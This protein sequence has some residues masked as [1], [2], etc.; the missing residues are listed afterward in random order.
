[1]K[2]AW[3][4]LL[5]LLIPTVSAYSIGDWPSFFVKDNKFSARYVVSDEAPSLDVVSATVISTSLAKFENLTIDVGTS[6]LDSEVGNITTI[7]A[8]VVASPC[9]SSSAFELM[10]RPDPCYRDLGGSVGYI[11][12]F[13]H[14]TKMQLLITGLNEKDRNA[15][16]K[17]IAN[18]NLK[19][20]NLAEYVINSNSGSVP[21]FFDKKL[22]DKLVNKTP[23][24]IVNVSAS[25][26]PVATSAPVVA[27]P[28]PGAY[29][30]LETVPKVE[31]KGW[32]ARLWGWIA[33]LFT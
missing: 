7:N 10:G 29:E 2:K 23:E 3:W 33:G 4:L 15:A 5:L 22:L 26:L 31:K 11:K 14:G 27:S 6:M 32:W 19:G 28:I 9:D 25:P 17:F 13:H 12:L 18:T 24:P 21:A 8:I 20:I 16:A 30:P 1:M